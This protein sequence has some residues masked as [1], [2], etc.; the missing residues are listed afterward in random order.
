MG[1][2]G[3]QI[4]GQPHLPVQTKQ[5][6]MLP[7]EQKLI[8]LDY[9]FFL[10]W[11]RKLSPSI[12]CPSKLLKSWPRSQWPTQKAV[13]GSTWMEIIFKILAGRINLSISGVFRTYYP[14][15]YSTYYHVQRM[16]EHERKSR[17][18]TLQ[19]KSK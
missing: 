16:F 1:W 3:W 4:S 12:F 18:F 7:G 10:P 15:Y 6:V 11:F 5:I 2:L 8:T 19:I 17:I 13:R 14:T 9:W